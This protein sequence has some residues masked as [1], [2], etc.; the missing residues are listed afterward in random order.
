[1]DILD[2]KQ[3]HQPI[4][5]K[6]VHSKIGQNNPNFGHSDPVPGD[7]IARGTSAPNLRLG[8]REIRKGSQAE[9]ETKAGMCQKTKKISVYDRAIKDLDK[10]GE[11]VGFRKDG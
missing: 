1:L 2:P 3:S 7:P 5:T 4:E 11:D 10:A 9:R 6:R 8:E